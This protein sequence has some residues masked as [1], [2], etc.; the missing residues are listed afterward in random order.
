MNTTY[1]DKITSIV[2]Q[3]WIKIT[4]TI[5]LS[6]YFI[7]WV[8]SSP[9]SKHLIKPILQEHGLTLSADTS[10]RYNPFL[11]Q[12]TISD[13]TLYKQQQQEIQTKVLTIKE[14][15]LRLTLFRFLF[16]EIFISQFALNDA[17]IKI[18]KTPNQL[19]IAGFNIN[20]EATESNNEQTHES[21]STPFSYQIILPKLAFQQV[22]IDV[23]NNEKLHQINIEKLLISQLKANNKAQQVTL[24]LKSF[25]DKTTLLLSVDA[26][27]AQGQGE[28]NSQLSIS[29]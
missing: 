15:T 23:N 17:Y 11:S 20:N 19:T 25:V 12:L 13:L 3:K 9:L 21:E 26:N 24:N 5:F 29:G 14:L 22:H 27:F 4:A 7:L 2:T 16:D 28:I 6:L 1:L 18:E 8:I 10:I